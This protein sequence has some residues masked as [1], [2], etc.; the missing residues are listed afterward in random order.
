[1]AKVAIKN[2]N[3]TSFGGIYHIMDVSQSWALKDKDSKQQTDI[4]GVIYTYRCILTNNWMS[5]EKDI[6][7][8]YNERRAS[9]KNF[10]RPQH[11]KFSHKKTYCGIKDRIKIDRLQS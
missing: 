4:F 3:I 8:F 1:M 9:E 7:N 10:D 11:I 6:I 5:T 2:K